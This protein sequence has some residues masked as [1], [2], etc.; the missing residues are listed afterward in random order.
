MTVIA[1]P[2][3]LRDLA[4]RLKAAGQQIEQLQRQTRGALQASGWEGKDRQRFESELQRDL[5]NAAAVG[6]RL[7]NDY[8]T[9]LER[10]AK[11][12]DDFQRS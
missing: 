8:P 10:K 4:K 12:L 11:A 1:D 7:Q 5:K 9:A 6:R 3:K 2:T